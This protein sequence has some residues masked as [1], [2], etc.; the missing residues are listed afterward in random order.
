MKQ[1]AAKDMGEPQLIPAAVETDSWAH[2]LVVPAQTGIHGFGRIDLTV[3]ERLWVTPKGRWY[4][5]IRVAAEPRCRAA[6]SDGIRR[7]DA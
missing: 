3:R 4:K 1:G 2:V 6:S 5:L 7:K